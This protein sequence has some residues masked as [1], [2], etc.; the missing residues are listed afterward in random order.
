MQTSIGAFE[1]KTHFS[2]LLERVSHGEEILITRRGIAIAKLLP[3]EKKIED[4]GLTAKEMLQNL[5]K[6]L[7]KNPG[8]LKEWQKYRLVGRK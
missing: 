2:S 3:I 7:K 5:H 1:A 4:K 6:S 8:T